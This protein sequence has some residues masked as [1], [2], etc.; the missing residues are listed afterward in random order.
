MTSRVLREGPHWALLSVILFEI[1][2]LLVVLVYLIYA[3]PG[4]WFT[5]ATKQEW[6]GQNM[7]LNR[8]LGGIA[9][10]DLIVQAIDPSGLA[11]VSLTTSPF[12]ASDYHQV[13]WQIFPYQPELEFTF[14]WHSSFKPGK[15]SSLALAQT[16]GGLLPAKLTDHPDWLGQISGVGLFVRGNL[17]EPL[18]IQKLAIKPLSA[19]E[20]LVDRWREWVGTV[21]WTQVSIN[22][23]VG[24]GFMQNYPLPPLIALIAAIAVLMYWA[25]CRI[26]AWYLSLW[27]I[28]GIAMTAWLIVDFR[29]VTELT[30]QINH[31]RQTFAGK[32]WREKKLASEDALLFAFIEQVRAKLPTTPV[33]IV[34]A[35]ED[36][37]LRGRG[38]YHLYPHNVYFH[39]V[40]RSLPQA[41]QLKRGDYIAV[42]QRAGMQY[43]PAKQLLKWDGGEPIAAELLLIQDGSALFRVR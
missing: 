8:G 5:R 30:R 34:M 41:N 4:A 13:I 9:D 28:A 23:V 2:A 10:N 24:G 25:L 3:T 37:Y 35:A 39:P 22:S 1:A 21:P 29:W 27:T 15:V 33:R 6:S 12:Y 40:E 38:A 26:K 43:D 14:V 32:D 19:S 42:Y 7:S 31:T 11:I 18:A 16:P 20:L 36:S 17:R